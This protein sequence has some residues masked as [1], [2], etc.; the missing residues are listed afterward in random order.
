MA[1]NFWSQPWYKNYI[2]RIKERRQASK[3]RVT[4]AKAVN[5]TSR[6]TA[7]KRVTRISPSNTY[8]SKVLDISGRHSYEEA[9][10]S[11]SRYATGERLGAMAERYKAEQ[12]KI[13]AERSQSAAAARLQ[14]QAEAEAPSYRLRQ[15]TAPPPVKDTVLPGTAP[16]VAAPAKAQPKEQFTVAPGVKEGDPVY[17]DYDPVSRT[18][19]IT[20]W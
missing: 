12:A 1:N 18:N 13:A 20:Y 8:Q 4:R 11:R 19:I 10:A 2:Q 16:R 5:Q 6:A 17:G 7:S 14:E 15:M 3:D 9:A